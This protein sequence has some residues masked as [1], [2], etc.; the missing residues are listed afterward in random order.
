LTG[1]VA[2]ASAIL[3][4][5]YTKSTISE[6]GDVVFFTANGEYVPGA[7]LEGGGQ[8]GRIYARIDGQETV[9][10]SEGV[11]HY[12]T[13]TPD[14]EYVFYTE[15]EDLYRFDTKTPRSKPASIA[16]GGGI[17]GT[18]GASADGSTVYFADTKSLTDDEAG[19]NG[20]TAEERGGLAN[21][22]VW[23]QGESGSAT[24]LFIANLITEVAGN[25]EVGDKGDWVDGPWAPS[26]PGA[27]LPSARVT[28][29]GN[30]LL[31]MKGR[32]GQLGE[33]STVAFF[34]Y[35][36]A[37]GGSPASLLCV[38]CYPS[39][40]LPP[41]VEQGA[42]LAG[43]TENHSA[44]NHTSLLM[45]PR[46]LSEDGNR[47]FF[48]SED[49]LVPVVG[50]ANDGR[51]NVYEW[52]ADGEGSCRSESQDG[53]CLYLISTGSEHRESYFGDASANGDDV[54]FFTSERLAAS[55][56]DEAFDV[57][58]ARVNG[59]ACSIEGQ[60][61]GYPACVV[62][63][64]ERTPC[65]SAETCK[66]PPSEPPTESFPATAA[67]NGPGNLVSPRLIEKPIV[68]PKTAA[69]LRA[70]KLAK[71]LKLC[72]QDKSRKKRA[73]CEKTARKR[74]GPVKKAKPKG[75]HGK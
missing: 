69:Q 63:P 57:Y 52:E 71:A 32:A 45:I 26:V 35:R 27:N 34:R 40:S 38:T 65:T 17:L 75:G 25:E 62:P 70:E 22:Y 66:P 30:T 10:V 37:E 8:N 2:G 49:P 55:D 44:G 16:T 72:R 50:E 53:G 64:K 14:G 13:A 12:R 51:V 19:P 54:F 5:H 46:N 7:P 18:V 3:G 48:Q 41:T 15:G 43:Q 33:E 36:A 58:D 1:S 21:L 42:E 47:V 20:E 29:D 73:S 23:H 60:P 74:Y 31:F 39:G 28:P 24:T 56:E 61:E 67:F 11:A 68:K 6:D 59:G 4:S 9:A